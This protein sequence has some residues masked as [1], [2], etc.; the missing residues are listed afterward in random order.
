MYR[1]TSN[2]FFTGAG[3]MCLGLIQ[4]GV[5]VKQS[6]DLDKNAIRTMQ[7]NPHYFNHRIIWDD[8][9]QM[10]VLDQKQSDIQAFTYPCTKYSTIG[11][12]HGVR[13]GDELFLH[14]LRNIAIGQPEMY[15]VEN[16]PGMKK[17]TVVMEA[18]TK[19]PG[20]YINI[21]CPLDAA[22]W[23]PQERKRLIIFGTKREF[24]ISHPS[25]A[26][27]RPTIKSLLEKSPK[28][29]VNDTVYTRLKGG[30]RD[31]PIVV[32]PDDK[33]AIAPCCV[34]H[35][36]KDMG[37]RLVKDLSYPA[38]VR[39]FTIREYARLQ[40]VPDDFILP[41]KN[42]AYKQIGNGVAVPVARWIGEQAMRYFN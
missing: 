32:D 8:V 27:I 31:M 29:K 35:Y 17:F 42:Y 5:N 4:A 30:Y 12:I 2:N 1:P 16:V 3:L 14:A 36:A 10:L 39:P 37:T 33:N 40:G 7:M 6:V 9:T 38:G 24:N 34:A 41:Q 19:L 11:D 13:T 23:L 28:I 15:I 18:M 22:L 25:V 26:T 20:Y 21:F